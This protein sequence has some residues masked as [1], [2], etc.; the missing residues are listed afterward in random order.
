MHPLYK[1]YYFLLTFLISTF[2]KQPLEF[3]SLPIGGTSSFCMK[4]Y[5]L[6][7]THFNKIYFMYVS[8]KTP[9]QVSASEI[10]F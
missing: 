3:Y 2:L 7:C 6:S 9:L 4:P 1:T 5:G 8:I 10:H